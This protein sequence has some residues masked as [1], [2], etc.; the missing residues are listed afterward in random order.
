MFKD[1]KILFASLFLLIAI[2][3]FGASFY[4]QSKKKV[5]SNGN[6]NLRPEQ[7]VVTSEKNSDIDYDLVLLPAKDSPKDKISQEL[8][9]RYSEGKM[10]KIF[11]NDEL[12]KETFY[13]DYLFLF[14]PGVSYGNLA[15]LQSNNSSE[16][17]TF[18][19]S[20]KKFLD[21]NIKKFSYGNDIGPLITSSDYKKVAFKDYNYF[22]I[23][24]L[25]KGIITNLFYIPADYNIV[26]SGVTDDS[27]LN[28]SWISD[29][30]FKIVISPQNDIYY[31][32]QKSIVIDTQELPSNDEPMFIKDG[33]NSLFSKNKDG[34]F[35]FRKMIGDNIKIA[36]DEIKQNKIGVFHY[37]A[38]GDQ[39]FGYNV[40][41]DKFYSLPT[42]TFANNRLV[43]TIV[44]NNQSV[45]FLLKSDDNREQV[46]VVSSDLQKVIYQK[47]L[48][49]DYTFVLSEGLGFSFYMV[50][51]ATKWQDEYTIRVALY[52]KNVPVLSLPMDCD[53][54]DYAA[55]KSMGEDI[56]NRRKEFEQ[57]VKDRKPIK[58]IDVKIR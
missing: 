42:S 23:I 7:S 44:S 37:F 36:G 48:E 22:I 3:L 58:F 57:A 9:A 49:S 45:A 56:D 12:K 35:V 51:G 8:Y 13:P 14:N 10:E 31:Q 21:D 50:A 15:Y 29:T 40:N 11:S 26:P 41:E 32:Q 53:G 39:V 18:D 24:D 43:A 27:S 34:V 4:L 1:K 6:N 16:L 47:Y 38:D 46:V 52:D 25:E 19:K 33:A 28:P 54:C 2:I 30:K 17:F 5:L 20:K 55:S